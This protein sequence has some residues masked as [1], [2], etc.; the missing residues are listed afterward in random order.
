M[1]QVQ[2]S[3]GQEWACSMCNAPTGFEASTVEPSWAL[4]EQCYGSPEAEA[5]GYSHH[6]ELKDVRTIAC[7]GAGRDD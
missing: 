7:Y 6:T 1:K 3:D 2:G 4:C 5:A